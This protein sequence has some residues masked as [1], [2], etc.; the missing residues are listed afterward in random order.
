MT[1]LQNEI[2]NKNIKTSIHE[3]TEWKKYNKRMEDMF[4]DA[5]IKAEI[6]AEKNI[7]SKNSKL[8]IISIIGIAI[9][10]IIFI[11]VQQSSQSTQPTNYKNLSNEKEVIS[12]KSSYLVDSTTSKLADITNASEKKVVKNSTNITNTG[13]YY[14]QLGAFSI[15]KNAEQLAIKVKTKGFNTV[16]SIRDN[17]SKQYQIFI[18]SFKEKVNS[19]PKQLNLKAFGFTSYV[20]KANDTYTLD[21]G[22]FQNSSKL[23]SYVKK[24]KNQGFKPSVKTYNKSKKTYIVRVVDLENEVKAQQVR[25]KLITQGFKNSFILNL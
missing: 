17:D 1:K 16:V 7:R 6:E 14:I 25:R 19:R 11:K 15:K 4:D 5:E 2:N 23:N 21:L 3:N 20:K 22:V 13:R 9:L 24:L 8:R 18:G 12:S 10:G